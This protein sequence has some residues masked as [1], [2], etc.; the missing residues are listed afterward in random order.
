MIDRV[1]IGSTPTII[2]ER[3]PDRKKVVFVN[4]SDEDISVAPETGAIVGYGIIIKANGGAMTD[5]PDLQGNMHLGSW[6]GICASGSKN[7]AVTE[8]SRGYGT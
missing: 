7:L 8:M 1:S 4:N 6:W 5:E 3:N 2:I